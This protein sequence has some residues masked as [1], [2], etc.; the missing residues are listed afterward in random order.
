MEKTEQQM[1]DDFMD[2]IVK[3]I[4]PRGTLNSLNIRDTWSDTRGGFVVNVSF[5]GT[6]CES[7]NVSRLIAYRDAVSVTRIKVASLGPAS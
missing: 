2:E 5:E 3:I 6:S 7:I 1:V 4:E